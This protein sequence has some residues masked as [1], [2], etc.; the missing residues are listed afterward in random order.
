MHNKKEVDNRSFTCVQ[1]TMTVVEYCRWTEWGVGR[2]WHRQIGV[3]LSLKA[4]TIPISP[5]LFL[6]LEEN[7]RIIYIITQAFS[8]F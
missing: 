2:E 8:K 1:E 4:S 5:F 3:C 6:F 7:H